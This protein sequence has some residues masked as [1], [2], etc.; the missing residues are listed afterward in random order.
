MNKLSPIRPGSFDRA[1]HVT[2]TICGS[3]SPVKKI[4]TSGD[5]SV[6]NDGEHQLVF[7]YVRAHSRGAISPSIS[8]RFDIE[9]TKMFTEVYASA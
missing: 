7:V 4:N 1:P 2:G 5:M 6:V 3:S 8:S 9:E